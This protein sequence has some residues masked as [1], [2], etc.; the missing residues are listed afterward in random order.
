[1]R[2]GRCGAAGRTA[3]R[4]GDAAWPAGQRIAPTMRRLAGQRIAPNDAAWLAGQRIAPADAAWLAG[5]RIAP[6]DAAWLAGQRIAPAV[7]RLANIRTY[8]WAT[9]Y[10]GHTYG[11]CKGAIRHVWSP[12]RP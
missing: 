5:Q 3:M 6:N 11:T 12:R 4:T 8:G 7:R 9:A 1:M 10:A 2:I